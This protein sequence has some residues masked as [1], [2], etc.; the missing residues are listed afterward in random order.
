LNPSES[1]WKVEH[2]PKF[3]DLK[4]TFATFIVDIINVTKVIPRL[5][6]V[7]REDR[8]LLVEEIVRK[9]E[10]QDKAVNGA[11]G[12]YSGGRADQNQNLSEEE[13]REKRYEKYRL[14]KPFENK[15]Q[16]VQKIQSN[17]D[18]SAISENIHKGV[19]KI[20]IIMEEDVK[21]QKNNDE[22]RHLQNLRTERGKKRILRQQDQ[23]DADPVAG[24]KQ[25]IEQLHEILQDIRF[26][27]QVQNSQ[28][29][30][31]LDCSHLK[32]ALMEHA[33]DFIQQLYVH[34]MRESKDELN[35]LL[36]EFDD[37]I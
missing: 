7:F 15:Y 5:E 36:K 18:V 19:D 26:N 23:F 1:Q 16:Y 3:E 33:N 29:F 10:E 25:T 13:R 12:G 14:P 17:K 35:G 31:V 22:L 32:S 4:S 6:K 9:A 30:I 20:S 28:Q 24:Y 21:A 2:E 34:L 37:T 8:E 27:K 11:Q